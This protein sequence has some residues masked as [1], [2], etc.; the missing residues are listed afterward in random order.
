MNGLCDKKPDARVV[1]LDDGRNQ[2]KPIYESNNTQLH[3]VMINQYEQVEL[4]VPKV[5]AGWFQ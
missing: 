1:F 3:S 5:E 4:C 2:L